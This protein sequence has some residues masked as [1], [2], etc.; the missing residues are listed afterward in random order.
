MTDDETL[1][2]RINQPLLILYGLGTILGA[3]IYVLI[4]KV[5][6]EANLLA[7]LSFIV[8][9]VVAW[10]TALSYSKLVVMFPKSAGE[11]VYV[12]HGFHL[13]WLTLLVG[14]LII[15]TGV[16]SAATLANGFTGY[17]LLLIP[18]NE[19]MAMILVVAVLTV[20]AVWGIAESL[21]AAALI[22]VV[23]VFGLFVV[24]VFC[25]DVLV[26]I[27]NR[28]D[29]L[30]IPK[31]SV[32]FVGVLSGAFLAF[33]AFIGFEDMVNIVEEVKQPE[34]TMPKAI[35][36]VVIISTT[37][38]V[39]IAL[40]AVLSLPLRDLSDS[41][42]PLAEML[43][44]KNAGAA[45][46]VSVISVVA[47]VNGVLIQIV[48]A[49]RV[50]YGMSRQYGG[51]AWLHHVTPLT[52]TPAIATVLVG[53]SIIIFASFFPLM[54]LVKLTSFVILTIFSLVN[55]ALWKLQR[56]GYQPERELSLQYVQGMRSYPALAALL[57]IGMLVFQFSHS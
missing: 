35:F 13:K 45:N 47:I 43:A 29:Q 34:R 28:F 10:L 55:L 2:R 19:S 27:P 25:S 46:L 6:A 44:Q 5:A 15:F 38:Y 17:L 14:V 41:K 57:C 48:M 51:P 9:A 32:Q 3:G 7:P 8:A 54:V 53:L 18:V 31:S 16:V 12:E 22:T 36:W 40:V 56:D 50:C 21:F 52:K 30:F 1:A 42:A 26:E 49:S 37:L 33:Y 39:L 23:E 4:G 24:L 11:A 20:L